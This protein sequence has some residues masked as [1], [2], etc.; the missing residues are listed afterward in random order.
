MN[1]NEFIAKLTKRVEDSNFIDLKT[2]ADVVKV[3][4]VKDE[5]KKDTRENELLYLTLE[6]EEKQMIVQK[7]TPTTYTHLLDQIK[8]AGGVKKLQDNYTMWEKER[9]G[10]TLYPRLYPVTPESK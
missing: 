10:R 2:V 8:L 6:T 9:I 4:L 1:E 3:K 7:Y 5:F